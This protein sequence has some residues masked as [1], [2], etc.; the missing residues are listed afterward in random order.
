MVSLTHYLL[1]SSADNLCKQFGP[2]SGPTKHGAWSRS[3]LLDTLIVFLKEYFEKVNFEKK[4]QQ[5]TK[6]DEK[7]PSRQR[8]DPLHTG[9]P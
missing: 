8:V 6:D 4:S 9:N 1:L 7:L 5:M 3:K 2:R